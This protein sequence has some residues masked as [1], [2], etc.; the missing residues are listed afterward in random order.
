MGEGHADLPSTMACRGGNPPPPHAGVR[1]FFPVLGWVDGHW[2]H[3]WCRTNPAW[4]RS[5]QAVRETALRPDACRGTIPRTRSHFARSART[6]CKERL[7]VGTVRSIPQLFLQLVLNSLPPSK[8]PTF[9]KER[10]E[11]AQQAAKAA[12]AQA[13]AAEPAA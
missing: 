3:K 12:A 11:A 8:R 13:K 4:T 2:M 1:P 6:F 5:A 7:L 9:P 10:L